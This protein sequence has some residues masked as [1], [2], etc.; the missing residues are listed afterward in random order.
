[1]NKDQ[2]KGTLKNVVGK[3]QAE[4]G[5]IVGNTELQAKGLKK[6]VAGLAQ[7]N[8]GNAKE[9]VKDIKEAVKATV[10]SR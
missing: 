4:A 6:Q 7:K 8:L 3:V 1:M 10:Q 9:V 5:K 2:A